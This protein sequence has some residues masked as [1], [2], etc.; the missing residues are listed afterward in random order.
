[1]GTHPIFES[2][3]DCLTE[4]D[5]IEAD[6]DHQSDEDRDHVIE[7]EEPEDRDQMTEIDVEE[8]IIHSE[9]EKQKLKK[10]LKLKKNLIEDKIK[11]EKEEII[12]QDQMEEIGM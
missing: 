8:A 3:F 11:L 12:I 4:W 7:T 5:V 1:M 10:K 6:R 2:D 9:K